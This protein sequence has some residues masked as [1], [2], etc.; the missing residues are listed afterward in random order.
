MYIQSQ[1][2]FHKATKNNELVISQSGFVRTDDTWHQKPLYSLDTRLYFVTDGSGMLIS[3]TEKMPLEAGYVY[4]AP[5]GTKCGFYSTESVTK[6]YFHINLQIDESDVFA[7]Y[8]HFQ[9]CPISIQKIEELKKYY[10]S[11]DPH[12]HL[13]LKSEIYSIICEFMKQGRSDEKANRRYS[14]QVADAIGYIGA[15]LSAKLTVREISEAIFCSQ[16][17]LSTLF[18]S[19]VGQSVARYID[20]LLMSEAQNHLLYTERSIAK[21]SERLGFCDQFYFSRIF[22]KRFGVPPIHYRKSKK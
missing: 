4:L 15:H 12:D 20:D 10:F 3:E 9:K 16:S 13:F 8:T 17:K 14:P 19:E 21:I 22:R 7:N 18:K 11:T 5:C 1:P 2:L 6:L